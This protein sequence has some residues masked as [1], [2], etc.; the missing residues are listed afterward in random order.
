MIKQIGFALAA[1][2][3]VDAFLVR[4]TLVP[5]AMAVVGDLA[6]WLPRSLQRL[7]PDLDI[8][9]DGLTATLEE[10]RRAGFAR[11]IEEYEVGLSSVAA[12][13]MVDRAAPNWSQWRRSRWPAHRRG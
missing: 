9:G 2:T 3:L 1:G 7:L 10:V 4:M 11:S 13:V 8:E 6:W 12:P 5:A